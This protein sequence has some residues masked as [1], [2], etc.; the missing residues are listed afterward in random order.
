MTLTFANGNSGTFSYAV[1]TSAGTVTQA[2][3]LTRVLFA[4]PSGTLCQ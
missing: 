4:A 2:K 3:A 1:N